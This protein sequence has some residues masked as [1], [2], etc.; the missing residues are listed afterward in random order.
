MNDLDW[1]RSRMSFEGTVVKEPPSASREITRGFAEVKLNI[2]GTT[3]YTRGLMKRMD[4]DN[5]YNDATTFGDPSK[6]YLVGAPTMTLEI[7][8]NEK[9]WVEL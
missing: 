1:L 2:D 3:I 9:G 8:M 5:R 4:I 6:T 7:E